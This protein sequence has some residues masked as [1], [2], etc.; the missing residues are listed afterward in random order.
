MKEKNL[1]TANC[2]KLEA[3]DVI[4]L[5]HKAIKNKVDNIVI[6]TN[7]NDYLQLI[8]KW[9]LTGDGCSEVGMKTSTFILIVNLVK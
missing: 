9:L 1:N 6:I 4:Y 2:D 8:T 3:D 5:T 7:D